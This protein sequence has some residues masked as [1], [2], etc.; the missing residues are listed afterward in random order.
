MTL[1]ENDSFQRLVEKAA[2]QLVSTRHTV[3]GSFIDTPLLYPSGSTVVVRVQDSGGRF[4]VSDM[5]LGYQEADMMGASLVYARHA[6]AIAKNAGVGF[7]SHAFFVVEVTRDQL[8][9]A[10]ATIANCSLESVALAAYKLAERKSSDEA[11]KLYRRLIDVFTRDKVIK[12]AEILGQS[13]TKWHVATL[14]N[15]TDNRQTIFE[16][17]TKHHTSVSFAVTKFHDIAR[18]EKPPQRVAVVNQKSEFG[19]YLGLL[20]QAAHVIDRS[21]PD[22]TYIRLAEAA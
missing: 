22:R 3:A 21:V 8:S 5:G 7:D 2:S 1:A 20:S 12:D 13:T 11:D 19:T 14:V 6:Q 15:L 10:V 4:F 9:G 16:P 18:R 17:V